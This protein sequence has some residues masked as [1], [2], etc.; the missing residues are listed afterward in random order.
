M[1]FRVASSFSNIWKL[2]S[3]QTTTVCRSGTAV[4]T[5]RE[6]EGVAHGAQAAGGEE[7]A[8]LHGQVLGRPDLVLAHVH[9]DTGV[10]VQLLTQGAHEVGGVTL[11]LPGAGAGSVSACRRAWRSAIQAS[12]WALGRWEM[13]CP[14]MTF[15][16]PTTGTVVEKFLPISAGS[17]SRWTVLVRLAISLGRSPPGQRPGRRR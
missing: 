10:I 8:V 9:A 2:P 12:L 7:A 17:T 3:P 16:S 15:T 6:A 4:L 13:S 11:P 1:A 5:P 14:R